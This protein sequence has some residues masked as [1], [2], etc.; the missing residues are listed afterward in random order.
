MPQVL[1]FVPGGSALSYGIVT[2]DPPL[3]EVATPATPDAFT[4]LNSRLMIYILSHR[5]IAMDL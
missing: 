5:F 2:I 4:A 1:N 3:Y